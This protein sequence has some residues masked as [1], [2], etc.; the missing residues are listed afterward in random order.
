MDGSPQSR[1]HAGKPFS[2]VEQVWLMS[3]NEELLSDVPAIDVN[4]SATATLA[5]PLEACAGVKVRRIANG[6]ICTARTTDRVH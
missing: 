4:T 2:L 6:S 3:L 5:G 1:G